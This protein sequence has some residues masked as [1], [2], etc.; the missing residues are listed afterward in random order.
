MAVFRK[1]GAFFDTG[2]NYIRVH[3]PG[4]RYVKIENIQQLKNEIGKQVKSKL[5]TGA[6]V[7]S[8]ELAKAAAF[9]WAQYTDYLNSIRKKDLSHSYTVIS[10]EDELYHHGILGQKW[11]VRRFQN[12]DGSLTSAG[13]ERYGKL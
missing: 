10:S 11:G 13:R 9:L 1:S 6:T 8:Q 3:V 4:D 5:P 12:T 2:D 7:S